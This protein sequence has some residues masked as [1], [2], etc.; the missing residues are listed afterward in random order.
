[1]T[2]EKYIEDLN[3]YL[4]DID[5]DEREDAVEY[6]REYFEEANDDNKVFNDLGPA[7]KYA[8]KIKADATVKKANDKNKE[9]HLLRNVLIIILGIFSLP[10]TLPLL[11]SVIIAII[12]F[13]FII[14]VLIISGILIA[15]VG[16]VSI[17]PL[18]LH[19]F[20]IMNVNTAGGLLL[21]GFVI[22]VIGAILLAFVVIYWLIKIL[23]PAF[24]KWLSNIYKRQ[25]E[26][27]GTKNEQK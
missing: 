15:V 24:I 16:L 5:D 6:V 3:W 1:M 20:A 19:S 21:L 2:R 10:V 11:I 27:G 26:K 14:A 9:N 7:H 22:L 17:I 8:A 13:I 23:I 12:A 18:A 4:R 25:K